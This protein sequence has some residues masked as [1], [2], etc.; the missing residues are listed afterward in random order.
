MMIEAA[1]ESIA[2]F[3]ARA[4]AF[5]SKENWTVGVEVDRETGDDLFKAV[6]K[7]DIPNRLAMQVFNITGYLRS[8]LDHAVYASSVT[9]KGGEPSRTK[10]PFGDKEADVLGEIKRHRCDDV[11]DDVLKLILALKPY[12]AGNRSLWALNKIRNKTNHRALSLASIGAGKFQLG[13]GWFEGGPIHALSE[14]RSTCR[15]LTF[16]RFGNGSKYE[17]QISPTIQVVINKAFGLSDEPAVK[18]LTDLAD[19]VEAICLEI[20]VETARIRKTR[21]A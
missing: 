8:A 11:H 2:D 12:E 5:L 13:G 7:T 4:N 16:A 6:F 14:W 17:I 3:E 19:M 15:Q 10:F 18:V 20:Q 21:A 9:L 1:R